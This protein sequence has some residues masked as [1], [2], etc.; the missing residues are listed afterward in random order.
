MD[1]SASTP[2]TVERELGSTEGIYW[3]LDKL[4]CLNF[5]VFAELEG[6]LDPARLQAALSI[7]Q[8]EN[9]L[10]RARIEESARGAWFRPV[11]RRAAPLRPEVLGLRRWR[12]EVDHQLHRHFAT[13]HAPLARLLWFKGAGRKSV[14]AMCFHHAIADG[15]SGTRVLCDVLRRAT[16]D[17][18]P[19]VHKPARPSSQ[20]LD[21]IRQK[22]PLLGAL[23]GMRFWMARGRDALRFAQ[24]LPGYDPTPRAQRRVRTLPYVL[25]A[26]LLAALLTRAR[27]HGTT[28]HGALGAAQLC[29]IHG[30]F[31]AAAPRQLALNSLADLRGVLGGGLSEQDLGLYVTTLCTVHAIA[32]R[33]DF[34][35]LARELTDSLAQIIAAGDAN[36]IHG[37][38]PAK[39]A[40]TSGESLARMVQAIVALAPPSSMLTNI[41]RVD[42]V[43]LGPDLSLRALA[44]VVSPP[45]QHPV[46]V[47][48]S[49]YAGQ[50]FVNLLY[51]EDKLPR[52]RARAIGDALLAQLRSAADAPAGPAKRAARAR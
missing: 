22:P 29:A 44:F 30:Q 13:G 20:A 2:A 28:V 5:V 34:W 1:A 41:G 23:Q 17:R 36:L 42:G 12:D 32:A 3:L 33:P 27:A 9:P 18:S 48:A 49:S 4:Y 52:P 43:D 40:F 15:K 38:Y 14:V 46:C 47:T 24:Q 21:L 19:A 25:P 51:D 10:L 45:A 8:D 39:Q 26:P 11:S 50:G 16:V 7:V 37:V 6:R 35:A 31:E